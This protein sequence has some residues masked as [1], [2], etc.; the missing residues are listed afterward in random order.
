MVQSRLLTISSLLGR[1]SGFFCKLR[2]ARREGADYS[3]ITS[4]F[5]LLSP[6]TSIMLC[7]YPQNCSD[8]LSCGTMLQAIWIFLQACWQPSLT[9]VRT[10]EGSLLAFEQ[11]GEGLASPH[12]GISWSSTSVEE[13]SP[14]STQLNCLF[15]HSL[16]DF[17]HQEAK[18]FTATLLCLSHLLPY[19]CH[20]LWK[21]YTHST[22][23]AARY[24]ITSRI[25]QFFM[26][27]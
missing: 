12:V 1:Q 13:T 24:P 27:K 18:C 17:L 21:H 14:A 4:S 25:S 19:P 5:T 15:L 11:D 7:T 8:A 2:E 6:E 16:N 3:C 10:G 9:V 22:P 26:H 20:E 23:C